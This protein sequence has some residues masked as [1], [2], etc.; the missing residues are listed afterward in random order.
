[1]KKL[2]RSQLRSFTLAMLRKQGGVC[3]VCRNPVDTSVKGELVCDHDHTTGEIRGALHRSCNAALGKVDNAAGRWGAK[4]MEYPKIIEFLEN[5]LEY[6]RQ[7][8]AGVVYPFH[9]TEDEKREARNKKARVARA[10]AK[11]TQ[12]L[13]GK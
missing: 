7:P 3:A 9:K 8:G 6:Y 13:R 5:M 12:R 1:M 2:P 10:K 11:A 4:S